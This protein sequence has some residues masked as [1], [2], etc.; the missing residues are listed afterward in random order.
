MT[1]YLSRVPNPFSLAAP[2]AWFLAELYAYDAD[3]VVFPSIQVPF[4]YVL[5]RKARR[6]GGM[7]LHDPQFAQAQPDTKFCLMQHLLPVSLI[8]RYNAVSWSID[9]ILA[10]LKARDIWTAGGADAYADQADAADDSRDAAQ[11]AAASL[12]LGQAQSIFDQASAAFAKQL[13]DR[14][15]QNRLAIAGMT[16]ASYGLQQNLFGER[17]SQGQGTTRSFGNATMTGYGVDLAKLLQAAGSSYTA[18][19][20]G[21][22]GGGRGFTGV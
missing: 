19:G 14:A 3:L 12:D 8:Y 2:P 18:F 13:Q 22:G 21:G 4:A 5:A 9:N 10:E 16:P 7:N 11:K 17:L 6:T 20:G 1:N 15:F